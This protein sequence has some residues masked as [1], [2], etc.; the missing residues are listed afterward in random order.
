[1]DVWMTR[2]I[3]AFIKQISCLHNTDFEWNAFVYKCSHRDAMKLWNVWAWQQ[4]IQKVCLQSK[5]SEAQHLLWRQSISISG[6]WHD[7]SRF[8]VFFTAGLVSSKYLPEKWEKP[9]GTTVP[10]PFFIDN[11]KSSSI[12]NPSS[13]R[14][15]HFK[16]EIKTKFNDLQIP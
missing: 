8:F 9:Q 10:F 6:L 1:M 11:I 4:H 2:I 5:S 15:G 12:Y 3:F 7:L 13:K 14:L 16:M